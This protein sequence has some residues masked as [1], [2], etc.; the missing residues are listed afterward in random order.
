VATIRPLERADLPAVTKL[1]QSGFPD[2]ESA[3]LERHAAQLGTLLLDHPW[4]DPALPSLVASEGD[5]VVGFIGSHPRRMVLGDRE[6]KAACCSHLVVSS[7]HRGGA[8]G[9][10]LLREYLNLGQ[11]LTYS[12]TATEL[13]ARMWNLYG[14]RVDAYRSLE[15]MQL[16]RPLAWGAQLVRRRLRGGRVD[17]GIAPVGAIPFHVAGGRVAGRSAAVADP[18]LTLVPLTDALVLEHA[19]ALSAG[20]MLRPAYDADYLGWLTEQ[21]QLHA[22]GGEVVRRLVLRG[23]RPVGWFVY[24]L[25]KDGCSRVLQLVARDRD[26]DAVLG[27]LFHDARERGT[28]ALAGRP[29]RLI[30]EPLRSRVAVFGLAERFVWHTRDP[31]LAALVDSSRALI[32]R[33]DGEWW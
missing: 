27:E 25:R 13:V 9:A 1:I 16:F 10:L 30:T 4:V 28:L 31:E 18:D 2:G 12:D 11:E 6:L 7:R 17:R 22:G 20:A 14:G 33:L 24:V 5:Q 32:S 21:L 19:R 3:A 15:W 29:E 8:A 23:E 26:A